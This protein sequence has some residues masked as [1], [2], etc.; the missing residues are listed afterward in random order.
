MPCA[1]SAAILFC[2]RDAKRIRISTSTASRRCHDSC[3]KWRRRWFPLIPPDAE[4]LAGLELGGIPVVTL[5]SHYSG[6][7]AAFVRKAAKPH[8]TARLCE[9]AEISGRRVLLVEDIVTTGGQVRASAADLRR[10]GATISHALCVIDREEGRCEHDGS[11]H[12][13]AGTV[14]SGRLPFVGPAT[15]SRRRRLRVPPRNRITRMSPSALPGDEHARSTPIPAFGSLA[16]WERCS[17][18]PR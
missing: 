10:I 6:L 14:S 16:A 9:G 8:G 17:Q 7:P 12:H 3:Q 1:V 18:E 13:V 2:G 11:G 15:A 4:V 5:L